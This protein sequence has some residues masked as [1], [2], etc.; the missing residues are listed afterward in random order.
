[1]LIGLHS[2]EWSAVA[3]PFARRA[4][5]CGV[6]FLRETPLFTLSKGRGLG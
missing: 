4:P 6:K 3:L 1:M 2:P 5:V